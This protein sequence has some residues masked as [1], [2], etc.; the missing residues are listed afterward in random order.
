MARNI[1]FQ[2]SFLMGFGQSV[3]DSAPAATLPKNLHLPIEIPPDL[4]YNKLSSHAPHPTYERNT[5]MTPIKIYDKP[6]TTLSALVAAIDAGVKY[7][8]HGGA[9]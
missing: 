8:E 3:D 6:L 7:A 1:R 9:I 2:Q 4:C 5:T